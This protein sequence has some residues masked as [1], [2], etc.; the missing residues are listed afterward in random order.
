AVAFVVAGGGLVVAKHGNRSVSSQCG[1][2]DVLKYVGI[3]LDAPPEKVKRCIERIG[4]GFL[5]APIYH[6]AMKYALPTRREIGIRTIFNILGPLTNPCSANVQLLGVYSQ[7]LTEMFIHV[8]KSLG[9]KAASVVHGEDGFDEISITGRTLVS[10]LKDGKM[11]TYHIQPEDFGMRRATIDDIR[12]ADIDKNA[13]ILMSVLK[14]EKGPCRDVVLLNSGCV[15]YLSGKAPDIGR[16]IRIA[17]EVID[18][19]RALKKL[20]DLIKFINE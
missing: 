11:R 5:F 10:E 6:P 19:G 20:E 17:E 18:S 4:I 13:A 3:N 12:G 1:S 2:A 9:A 16:G 8:L 7:G 15:F 14:G